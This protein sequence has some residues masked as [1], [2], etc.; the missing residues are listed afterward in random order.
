MAF[1]DIGHTVPAKPSPE[2]D[3]AVSRGAK[4]KG[5]VCTG[6]LLFPKGRTGRSAK[7]FLKS[8]RKY[9]ILCDSDRCGSGPYAISGN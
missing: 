5:G 2:H 7:H 8:Y 3:L 4:R 6:S 9:M 1:H